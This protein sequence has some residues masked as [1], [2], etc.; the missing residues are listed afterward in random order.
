MAW[1]D[2]GTIENLNKASQFVGAV[3][4]QQGRQIACLEEIAYEKGFISLE[5]LLECGNE[6]SN[7][8]YG[9][10]ILDIYNNEKRK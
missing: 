4:S 3:Q 8:E 10:Y 9:K 1:L 2:T 7:S 6:Q 5:Q